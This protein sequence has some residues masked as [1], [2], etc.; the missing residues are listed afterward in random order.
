MKLEEL[1]AAVLD[2]PVSE[3]D[4]SVRRRDFGHWNSVKHIE[5]VTALEKAYGISF[6]I[7]EVIALDSVAAVRELLGRKGVNPP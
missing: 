3:I 7:A 1:F 2:I 4:D 6:A 5:L